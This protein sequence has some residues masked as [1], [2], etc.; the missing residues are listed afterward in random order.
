MKRDGVLVLRRRVDRK[1]Y[2]EKM[3]VQPYRTN[4][5]QTLPRVRSAS[6]VT[7]TQNTIQTR[8]TF[9]IAGSVG[10][11]MIL[12]PLI[13]SIGD[14]NCLWGRESDERCCVRPSRASFRATFPALCLDKALPSRVDVL[15]LERNRYTDRVGLQRRRI[16][17]DAGC[18]GRCLCLI[19]SIERRR[20]RVCQG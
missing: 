17:K 10:G 18:N 12:T 8:C 11:E 1:R 15:C 14:R 19:E 5:R 7:D 20:D 2:L 6:V 9:D 13:R 4:E 3:A 16:V